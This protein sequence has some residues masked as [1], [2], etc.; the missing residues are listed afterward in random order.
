MVTREG[1]AQPGEYLA[2][3]GADRVRTVA[4][5]WLGSTMGCCECHDHKFD[6]FLTKDFYSMKAFF[7]DIKQ[8]GVYMDYGYTPNPDF[9]GFS[10]DHP[11]PPEITV[12]SPYLEKR[13]KGIEMRIAGLETA[14]AAIVKSDRKQRK[15]FED[16]WGW[17]KGFLKQNPTGWVVLKPAGEGSSTNAE[18]D[19][20]AGADGSILFAEKSKD[21]TEIKLPLPAGWVSAI[22]LELIPRAEHG[23][24]VLIGKVK[25]DSTMVKLTAAAKSKGSKQQR[26]ISFYDA[27]AD[28]K[29]VRY[30][31]GYTAIGVKD[32]WKT[33]VQFEKSPQTAVYLLDEPIKA[34][35]GDVLTVQLGKSAVGCARIS[36]SPFANKEPLKSG[37]GEEL[38]KALSKWF[39]KST[40]QL[41]ETYLLSAQPGSGAFAEFK[42]L[43]REAL[44]C[45]GGVSP[46]VV[47]VLREADGDKSF[48]A[49]Q[50][51]GQHWR[52]CPT[53]DAAFSAAACKSR[54]TAVDAIGSGQVAGVAGQPAHGARSHEPHM[55]TILWQWHFNGCG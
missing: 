12:E 45:R 5:T 48:G 52:G 19:F 25:N 4:T 47:T 39:H 24:N 41:N 44:D 3:Y 13:L 30:V 38:K 16:W 31:N 20:T 55:E 34:T 53:G 50:L 27:E 37:G 21:D 33:S 2:K 46:T 32:G 10:N 22:R 11:F 29:E 36:V 28:H 43:Y 14:S 26:T 42:K 18:K 35:N 51:A 17:S 49:R 6:P 23:G 15:A 9:K 7:A 1:G 40:A 8:W 54:G